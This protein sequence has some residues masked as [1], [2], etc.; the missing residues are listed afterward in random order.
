MSLATKGLTD[1]PFWGKSALQ[2]EY[3]DQK[4]SL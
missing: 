3:G 4:P 1:E 2:V